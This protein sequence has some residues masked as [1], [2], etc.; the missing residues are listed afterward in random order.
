LDIGIKPGNPPEKLVEW[1]NQVRHFIM[2]L[3]THARG[4]V[5]H[6]LL[7]SVADEVMRAAACPVIMV[8]I[9]KDYQGWAGTALAV[10][11]VP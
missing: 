9:H 6:I 7:G 11:S 5:G 4:G 2:A 8:H 3:A 1:S 10:K